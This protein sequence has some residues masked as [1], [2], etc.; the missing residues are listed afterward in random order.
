RLSAPGQRWLQPEEVAYLAQRFPFRQLPA[1]LPIALRLRDLWR[2]DRNASHRN[3]WEVLGELRQIVAEL[4]QSVA[5]LQSALARPVPFGL[6]S[7]VAPAAPAEDDNAGRAAA[8]LRDW[9]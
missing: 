8:L 1:L 3:A 7:G 9:R 5:A 2:I 4:D 6:Q